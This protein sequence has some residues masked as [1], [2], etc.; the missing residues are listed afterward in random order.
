MYGGAG[1]VLYCKGLERSNVWG[2]VCMAEFTSHGSRERQC[3]G[4]EG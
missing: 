3:I 2:S 4:Y 1:Q